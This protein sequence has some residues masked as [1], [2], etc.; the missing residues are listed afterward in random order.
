MKLFDN[1]TQSVVFTAGVWPNI[2]VKSEQVRR[3]Y[4]LFDFEQPRVIVPVG[5]VHRFL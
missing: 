5:A 1:T 4:L 2:G 3:I